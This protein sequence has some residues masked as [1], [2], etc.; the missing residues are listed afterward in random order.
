MLCLIQLIHLA[1]FMS[2][3]FIV[4]HI[5]EREQ[6]C[7]LERFISI[8]RVVKRGIV[9]DVLFMVSCVYVISLLLLFR[10]A[11]QTLLNCNYGIS[12]SITYILQCNNDKIPY[13]SHR[14]ENGAPSLQFG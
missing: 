4:I 10:M 11:V 3:T 8:K 9:L 13:L 14:I 6:L 12:K 7:E 1:S 2:L 5:R